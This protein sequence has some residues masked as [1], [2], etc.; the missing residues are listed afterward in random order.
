MHGE[1]GAFTGT[2]LRGLAEAQGMT[3]ASDGTFKYFDK[4]P[5]TGKAQTLPSFVM[6]N[7]DDYPFNVEML[8]TSVV[9]GI[10]FQLDIPHVKHCAEA[11]SQMVQVARQMA[12]SL[13]SSLVAD[14]NK[15]LGDIQIEKIRQQLKVIHA[16]MLTRGIV[17]G[18]ECALRLFS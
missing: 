11:Y 8:R 2:K 17:P 6:F 15:V 14:N 10:T 9:K 12:I 1:N 13:N 3:L 5:S 4:D 16:S 7:R 18:S